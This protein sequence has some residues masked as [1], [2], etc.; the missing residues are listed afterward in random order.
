MKRRL[1]VAVAML[2]TLVP[3]TSATAAEPSALPEVTP[4][5]ALSPK[6]QRALTPPQ[7]RRK[8]PP[9]ANASG[10]HDYNRVHVDAFCS[11]GFDHA[12]MLVNAPIVKP[13]GT[14]RYQWVAFKASYLNSQEVLQSDW[15]FALAANWGSF[16]DFGGFKFINARTGARQAAP[17]LL[18]RMLGGNSGVFMSVA[19]YQGSRVAR[20]INVPLQSYDYTNCHGG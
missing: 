7:A 9:R 2:A 12:L 16:H 10:W 17:D 3:A 8:R 13:L 19:W 5:K 20:H 15:F 11:Y 18:F 4:P 14:N 1:A 6:L